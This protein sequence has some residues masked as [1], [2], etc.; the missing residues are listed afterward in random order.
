M[1]E[2]DGQDS[3][4]VFSALAWHWIVLVAGSQVVVRRMEEFGRFVVEKGECND[5]VSHLSTWTR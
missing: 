1:D 3:Y 2:C 5:L 4:E